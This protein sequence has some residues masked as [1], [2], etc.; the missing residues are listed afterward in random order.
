[1]GD[2]KSAKE[3]GSGKTAF[4]FLFTQDLKKKKKGFNTIEGVFPW[5]L[6]QLLTKQL[7]LFNAQLTW[8]KLNSSFT[9]LNIQDQ[10]MCLKTYKTYNTEVKYI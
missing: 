6:A 10:Q 8:T 4:H 3:T 9:E 2:F 7:T 5:W 1:M